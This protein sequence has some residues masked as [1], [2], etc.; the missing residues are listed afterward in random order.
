MILGP[1]FQGVEYLWTAKQSLLYVNPKIRGSTRICNAEASPGALKTGGTQ[2]THLTQQILPY[3]Q[4]IFPQNSWLGFRPLAPFSWVESHISNRNPSIFAL[5]L[6][7]PPPIVVALILNKTKQTKQHNHT[8]AVILVPDLNL[9]NTRELPQ[10][11]KKKNTKTNEPHQRAFPSPSR[12]R[13]R[14]YKVTSV[15]I[16]HN[17]NKTRTTKLL[18][19]KLGE[20]FTSHLLL[21]FYQA[22]ARCHCR[23][24]TSHPP[25]RI[26]WGAFQ[27]WSQRSCAIV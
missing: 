25:A 16:Y 24:G 12:T 26:L 19:A 3:Y 4:A 13:S 5:S 21:A 8:W 1:W 17:I 18:F 15:Q 7:N 22:R 27:T 6:L 14:G 9:D 10:I 11:F 23:L 20:Y 2:G